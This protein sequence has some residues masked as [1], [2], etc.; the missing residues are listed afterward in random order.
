MIIVLAILIAMLTAAYFLV[1]RPGVQTWI[2]NKITTQLSRK[3]NAKISIGKVD[4]VF[5]KKL[6]LED[7]L[8]ANDVNDTILYSK[9]VSA[10][11]DSLN[12]K[13]RKISIEEIDIEDN[14]AHIVHDSLNKFNFS[15]IFDSLRTERKSVNT[16]FWKISFNKFNLKDTEVLYRDPNLKVSDE[17]FIHQLNTSISNFSNFKDSI[18]FNIDK[19]GLYIGNNFKVESTASEFVATKREIAI[20]NLNINSQK[21]MINH[22]DFKLKFAL[23][24]SVEN[25][26]PEFDLSIEPSIIDFNEFSEFLPALKGMDQLVECSGEIYGNANDLKGKN[27][28][29]KTGLNTSFKLDFYI[30]GLNDPE[31]MYLFLDLKNFQTTFYDISAFH[32]PEKSNIGK[33]EFPD[34]FYDAGLLQYTGNFSGFI[35]DFVTFGT[36]KSSLGVVT[37]DLS[38]VPQKDKNFRYSGKVSTTD[39]ALGDFL[40][41]EDLGKISFNAEV[42]GNYSI[43]SEKLEGLFKGDIYNIDAHGYEYRNIKLD[44]LFTENMFDGMV[45]MNDSN[46]QFTFLGDLNLSGDLPEFDFNLH[47]DKIL[48]AKLNLIENFP[49]SELGFSM[50][51]RFTGNKL[52]NL[53]GAILV[54]DGYYKNR[55]GDFSLKGI[56]LISIPGENSSE[57]TFNSEYFDVQIKGVYNFQDIEYAFQ[58]NIDQFLPAFNFKTQDSSA[59][60]IF[61]FKINA[62]NLNPLTE[63]FV[64][65][66]KFE[67]PFFLYGR[68]NSEDADFSIEGSIPGMQ[69]KKLTFKNI[70]IGNKIV[71]NH[72]ASKF[73]LAEIDHENGTSIYDLSIDSEIADNL[74]KNEIVWRNEKGST[75]YSSVKTQIEFTQNAKSIYPTIN[76]EFLPTEILLSKSIWQF[77]TFNAVVDSSNIE[78]K[79]FNLHNNDQSL[80]ING[81]ISKDSADIL[82][83]E[84]K[85]IDLGKLLSAETVERSFHGILNGSV[86]ISNVYT[87]PVIIADADVDNMEFENQTIGAVMLSSYWDPINLSVNTDL[88]IT[89]NN[90]QSL[91]ANGYY[92]PQTKKLNYTVKADSLPI[93]LLE[94]V[95]QTGFSDFS[96][97]TSG[98]VKFGGDLSKITMDGAMKASNGGLKIDYTQVKYFLDDSIYFKTDTILFDNITIHDERNNSGKFNG[99]IVHDNFKNMRYN[100]SATSPNIMVLKTT[101]TDNQIF[102]G[103][104]FA[105]CKLDINGQGNSIALTG[106]GT[107][108]P[109]TAV[110]IN[111]E[112]ESELEQYDFLR[113]INNSDE[114]DK[115]YTSKVNSSSGLSLGFTVEAT[116]DAKVQLIYNSQIGDVIKGEG[117]GILLFNMNKYG[118]ISLSGNY[119]VTKGDYLFTLQNVINKRFTIAPGGTIVWAG[120]PYNANIDLKAIYKLKASLSDLP[121]NTSVDL[122]TRIPVDCIIH[123]TDELINPTIA[124]DI[125]FPEENESDK[126]ELLQYFNTDEEK[127]K[128]ILS[129]IVLGKFYTPEYMRGQYEAQNPNMIGTTASELFSNQLSNW[130]SQISNNWDVGFNYRPGNSI[131]NDELELALSTQIFNDRVILNGNIGNNINPESSNS[132][133]IV[134]DVDVRVKLVPSGKIQLKAFNHSNNNLIYETA[135]YTQGVGLSFNEEYNTFGELMRKIAS[136]FK[137]ND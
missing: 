5:F 12:F 126:N 47:V 81:K 136:L 77:E 8:I 114:E 68:M 9:W 129:L 103:D 83:A 90:H 58:Q 34:S 133:Q 41:F 1:Q 119:T 3:S 86:S 76:I 13:Q 115:N 69:Y 26:L 45:S 112:Y 56:Q 85:N 78:I 118:E 121:I 137:K 130:L 87:T 27:V 44:G 99:T 75:K 134:G 20:N 93:K 108:L 104:A 32:F 88:Q 92:I 71:N 72:Y 11:V 123:L 80:L 98:T 79:N 65:E 124:L 15:F 2:I 117:D 84:I 101:Y 24:D 29:V 94:T 55:F 42:S 105:N 31:T 33:F 49:K 66:L 60:N 96:G 35:S 67:E 73:N 100:M 19:I 43:Q 74:L 40:A 23:P 25:P 102:Y 48:P 38:V 51:A 89:N 14:K 52:D 120:D 22:L 21:S 18:R 17:L 110:N 122:Y 131:T 95:I 113:F 57:L 135:P 10:K 54:D 36:L 70:F 132:S 109:G 16:N 127:N 39:F 37:T 46:L 50:R 128:Q 53:R 97:L 125:D 91:K 30:N 107:S 111:M 82:T 64:P 106:Y 59:P 28:V 63:V 7:V 4:I 116:P 6:I 62:K 61:D